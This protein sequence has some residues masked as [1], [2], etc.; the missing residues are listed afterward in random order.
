MGIGKL[1]LTSLS[2]EVIAHDEVFW[3]AKNQLNFS[4]CEQNG[5]LK[6][7]ELIDSGKLQLGLRS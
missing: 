4:K 1:F 2:T 5:A 7:G 6:L 3:I